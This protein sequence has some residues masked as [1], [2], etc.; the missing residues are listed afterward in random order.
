LVD[1]NFNKSSSKL[2]YR[3]LKSKLS[4]TV[5]YSSAT[6]H[7]TIPKRYKIKR[8]HIKTFFRRT[9]LI[10]N[11]SYNDSCVMPTIRVPQKYAAALEACLKA[12]ETRTGLKR[13]CVERV[14][15]GNKNIADATKRNYGKHYDGLYQFAAMIGAYGTCF[16]LSYYAPT[17]ICPSTDDDVVSLYMMYK[18][19]GPNEERCRQCWR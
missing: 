3:F 2:N 12:F 14:R 8:H 5:P 19:C 7:T 15:T 16:A 11:N 9:V 6:T 10:S 17:D 18:W 1:A 13:T 4:S